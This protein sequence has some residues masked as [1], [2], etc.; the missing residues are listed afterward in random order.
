MNFISNDD[1]IRPVKLFSSLMIASYLL[2]SVPVFPQSAERKVLGIATCASSACHGAAFP[3]T[4]SESQ[5][6]I[7][8]N[9][10]TIWSQ[11]D[12]HSK[13]YDVLFN[14]RSRLL[15]QRLGIKNAESSPECLTCHAT[16]SNRSSM[17]SRYALKEGVGCEACH[18]AAE[19]YLKT[20]VREPHA[21]AKNGMIA[22]HDPQIRAVTCLRCHVGNENNASHEKLFGAGHPRLAFELDTYSVTQPAHYRLD[23]DYIK[24]KGDLSSSSLWFVGQWVQAQT[25]IKRM[26]STKSSTDFSN[27]YCLSCHHGLDENRWR[28]QGSDRGHLPLNIAS[29]Q[30]ITIALR[31]IDKQKAQSLEQRL[32][33]VSPEVLSTVTKDLQNWERGGLKTLAAQVKAQNLVRDLIDFSQ[34]S[35]DLRHYEVGEQVAMAMTSALSDLARH[36]STQASEILKLSDQIIK[37]VDQPSRYLP[38]TLKVQIA[39]AMAYLPPEALKVH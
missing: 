37:T 18:G 16:T 22:L 15:A 6:S 39:K 13:A 4:K 29:L 14:E 20:H 12:R 27:Y 8:R 33:S 38:E 31:S 19:N 23:D 36:H 2:I 26:I 25:Q 28:L 7:Q 32:G 3:H 10:F 34:K 35:P 11:D 17:G 9:E 24:R 30:M 21:N 5:N 1:K